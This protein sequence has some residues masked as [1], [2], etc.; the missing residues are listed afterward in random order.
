M[1]PKTPLRIVDS[2]YIESVRAAAPVQVLLSGLFARN[3]GTFSRVT[4]QPPVLGFILRLVAIKYGNL[5]PSKPRMPILW[6][7]LLTFLLSWIKRTE[8]LCWGC[9]RKQVP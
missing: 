7:H 1:H 3:Q 2:L 8:P 6:A 5:F 9:F 4:S